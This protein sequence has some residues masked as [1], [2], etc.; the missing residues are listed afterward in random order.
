MENGYW[1]A[2]HGKYGELE[3][4]SSPHVCMQW[5][6]DF[7]NNKESSI[8]LTDKNEFHSVSNEIGKSSHHP[9]SQYL[10]FRP[11]KM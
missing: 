7:V 6:L 5:K 3:I 10:L 4:S 11:S 8:G 1:K 2:S 9:K